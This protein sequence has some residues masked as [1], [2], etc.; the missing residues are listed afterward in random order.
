MGAAAIQLGK[1]RILVWMPP[2]CFIGHL[3]LS[4]ARSKSHCSGFF[5]GKSQ[6]SHGDWSR[7]HNNLLWSPVLVACLAPS[8]QFNDVIFVIGG[9]LKN[10]KSEVE[11]ITDYSYVDVVYEIVGGDIFKQVNPS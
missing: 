11:A 10:M 1:V 4:V 8:W 9:N 7:P 5:A 2:A 3:L 6:S